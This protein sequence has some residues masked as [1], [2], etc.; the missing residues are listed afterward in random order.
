MLE[1]RLRALWAAVM[2]QAIRDLYDVDRHKWKTIRLSAL[3]WIHNKGNARVNSFIGICRYLGM[4]PD[5]TRGKILQDHQVQ[6]RLTWTEVIN[7]AERDISSTSL[8]DLHDRETALMWIKHEG[9]GFYSFWS[10]CRGAG[11]DP[12]EVRSRILEEHRESIDGLMQAK[13]DQA[14]RNIQSYNLKKRGT[15][16]WLNDRVSDGAGSFVWVCRC[17]GRDPEKV[18]T[19][20]YKKAESVAKKTRRKTWT[21]KQ[22]NTSYH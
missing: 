14:V 12:G 6:I 2:E 3:Y 21:R 18:R 20:I 1:T 17:L 10:A 15:E 7:E 9:L 11:L 13:L 16:E 22:K 19:K 5:K 4:D 8:K